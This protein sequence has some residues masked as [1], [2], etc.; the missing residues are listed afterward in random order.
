LSTAIDFVGVEALRTAPRLRLAEVLERLGSFSRETI[1]SVLGGD[2][3]EL[4]KLASSVIKSALF[5]PA[6]DTAQTLAVEL[7]RE[8][9]ER[10]V[11]RAKESDDAPNRSIDAIRG[12]RPTSLEDVQSAIDLILS[13]FTSDALRRVLRLYLSRD[14]ESY[15]SP[16]LLYEDQVLEVSRAAERE[17]WLP[18]LLAALRRAAPE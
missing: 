16:S 5:G 6:K 10:V 18:D 11:H 1:D 15:A 12:A 7:L 3:R 13:T 14:L 8:A 9:T 17:G 2:R 4:A